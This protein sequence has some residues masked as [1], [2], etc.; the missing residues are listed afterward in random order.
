MVALRAGLNEQAVWIGTSTTKSMVPLLL[1]RWYFQ[2][3]LEL[4]GPAWAVASG[5][6]RLIKNVGLHVLARKLSCMLHWISAAGDLGQ[7]L[8]ELRR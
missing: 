4:Q 5:R 1:L 3:S 2:R 6:G 7:E 8:K